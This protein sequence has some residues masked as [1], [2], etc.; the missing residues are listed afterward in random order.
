MYLRIALRLSL[1]WGAFAL[2]LGGCSANEMMSSTAC[3]SSPPRCTHT[4]FG[5][6]FQICDSDRLLLTSTD[7][8][9]NQV[10][11]EN[12][13]CVDCLPG[14]NLCNDL[15]T[16]VHACRSD[17]TIG[18]LVKT[19][20]M[21]QVCKGGQCASSSECESSQVLCSGTCTQT[22][23][24]PNNC[25]ACGKSCLSG[26]VHANWSCAASTCAFEGCEPG[27]YD[28]NGDHKCEYACNFV[29]AT[30]ACN[31]ADENCNGQVD[32]GAPGT[33][34]DPNHCGTCTNNCLSGAVHANWSCAAG[35]CAFEGCEPGFYDL[36]GDHK[37]E[38]AC[39]FV[40]SEESCNGI[41]DDCDG[42]IDENPIVP[43]PVQVCGVSFFANSTQCTA[44]AIKLF[45][46]SGAWQCTFPAGVCS[47]SCALA[48]EIPDGLDNDCNGLIDEP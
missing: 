32:E 31:G 34:S 4:D 44:P 35:T 48:V 36:N 5:F 20:D 13:G 7:C 45:C 46:V 27:F 38:Y 17:G 43:T 6:V 18:A 40:S 10:C 42:Q 15:A 8:S 24:D 1:L 30:E 33:P 2:V 19:C 25:G 22:S 39:N 41:D 12:L 9:A 37:C 14:T 28:L 26:A 47:P 29:S 16:A 21:G 3:M 23:S 11:D